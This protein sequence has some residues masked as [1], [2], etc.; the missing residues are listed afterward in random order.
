MRKTTILAVLAATLASGPSTRAFAQTSDG[1]EGSISAAVDRGTEPGQHAAAQSLEASTT[2]EQ[3]ATG[4]GRW[5]VTASGSFQYTVPI[6]L[7]AGRHGLAPG[8]SLV[9]DSQAGNGL[10]G[11]GWTLSGLPAIVRIPFDRGIR[12]DGADHYAFAA[13]GP[14]N[15][16]PA[17]AR[18]VRPGDGDVYHT[19]EESWVRYEQFGTCGSGPCGFRARLGNGT[20]LVFGENEGAQRW[21]RDAGVTR[22]RGV[23]VWALARAY[24]RFGNGYRVSYGA[25]RDRGDVLY[26]ARIRWGGACNESGSGVDPVGTSNLQLPRLAGPASMCPAEPLAPLTK[27]CREVAFDYGARSDATPFPERYESRLKVVTVWSGGQV[28]HKHELSYADE[29]TGKPTRRSHLTWLQHV[30]GENDRSQPALRFSPVTDHF[31][32]DQ[33][34][35]PLNAPSGLVTDASGI[36]L[37]RAVVESH[38]ADVNGDGYDDV[39][40]VAQD[41]IYRTV[42]TIMGRK[43]GVGPVVTLPL[44]RPSG[45]TYFH[46][47]VGDIN[48]DGRSDLILYRLLAGGSA[49]ILCMLGSASGLGDLVEHPV[50]AAGL[51]SFVYGLHSDINHPEDFRLLAVDVNGDQVDDLVIVNLATYSGALVLGT[52]GDTLPK[53]FQQL[54]DP[55]IG[56]P[57]GSTRRLEPVVVDLDGDGLLDVVLSYSGASS[58]LVVL[59]GTPTG[60]P[61]LRAV[62]F[63]SQLDYSPV[64]SNGGDVN[65]DGIG[66]LTWAY[67]GVAGTAYHRAHTRK[68]VGLLGRRGF[69]ST[70]SG[71]PGWPIQPILE[72]A[73]PTSSMPTYHLPNTAFW[74]HLV[75]DID[76]DGI[77]DQVMFYGGC[78][79]EAPGSGAD[80]CAAGRPHRVDFALGTP[81]GGLGPMQ[82]LDMGKKRSGDTA[83]AVAPEVGPDGPSYVH[84]WKA[85]LLDLD[86]DGR[87]DLVRYYSGRA[88]TRVD[89]WRGVPGGFAEGYET[90]L[91]GLR[92]KEFS[93]T[94]PAASSGVLAA[95]VQLLAPDLNGDGKPDLVVATDQYVHVRLSVPAPTGLITRI[96]NGIHGALQ[97]D[98]ESSNRAPCAVASQRVGCAALPSPVNPARPAASVSNRHPRPLAK[99]ITEED[100]FRTLE[101]TSFAFGDGRLAPGLVADRADLGFY[102]MERIAS[103]AG[104]SVRTTFFQD[105]H[106]ARR[107]EEQVSAWTP[108]TGARVELS[109]TT[110]AYQDVTLPAYGTWSARLDWQLTSER[111]QG[112]PSTEHME[113]LAYDGFG[114]VERRTRCHK[115]VAEGAPVPACSAAARCTEERTEYLHDSV[116]WVLGLPTRKRVGD[117]LTN[118]LLSHEEM[119]YL[120]TL[121]IETASILCASAEDCACYDDPDACVSN[122][123]ARRVLT[124]QQRRYDRYG[125]PTHQIDVAGRRTCERYEPVFNTH[126]AGTTRFGDGFVL[127]TSLHHDVAGRVVEARDE[128]NQATTTSY[129]A[130][131]RPASVTRPDGGWDAWTYAYGPLGK[132]YLRHERALDAQRSAV[133][134]RYF[135]GAGQVYYTTALGEDGHWVVAEHNAFADGGY[136]RK[137]ESAPHFPDEAT[138][139]WTE[140]RTDPRGR[141]LSVTRFR[142]DPR[143]GGVSLGELASFQYAPRRTVGTSRRAAVDDRGV[144][145]G[146]V[147]ALTTT[148]LHDAAGRVH[149]IQDAAGGITTFCFDNAGRGTEIRGPKMATETYTKQWLRR[150]YDGWGRT[151]R[152]ESSA[153]G[154]TAITYDDDG[155][156]AS[157]V[158]ALGRT[159]SSSYDVLGRIARHTTPEG[160]TTYT[161]ETALVNGRGRLGRVEG[162]W[163]ARWIDEY[164]ALGRVMSAQS[165]PD[166]FD[167]PQGERFAVD[168]AGRLVEHRLPD[169]SA[170]SYEYGVGGALRRVLHDGVEQARFEDFDSHLRPRHVQAPAA[171]S[172]LRY[173]DL[174]QLRELGHVKGAGPAGET[175]DQAVAARPGLFRR[176]YAFDTHGDVLLVRD[177]LGSLGAASL[178]SWTYGYDNL[179]RL[180][181]AAQGSAA[182]APFGYDIRGN[183]T[184]RGEHMALEHVD[185]EIRTFAL[186]QL[187]RVDP[188]T[189]VR[190]CSTVRLPGE[191]ARYDAV[192]NVISKGNRTYDYDSANRLIR[193][194]DEA[195]KVVASFV[196]D[197]T[198]ARIAKTEFPG[199][200]HSVTTHYLGDAYELRR[201]N[202]GPARAA[203]VRVIAPGWGTVATVTG[204]QLPGAPTGS[205]AS[206]GY[207]T[208]TGGTGDGL[209]PGTWYPL[210]D[211]LG[212]AALV[213]DRDGTPVASYTYDPFGDVLEDRSSGFDLL[214]QKFTGKE[215][216]ATTGLVYYG[217][218]YY[219]PGLARFMTA[220]TVIPGGGGNPQ[221]LNRYAYVLGNPVKMVDPTGHIPLIIAGIIIYAPEITA[222]TAFVIGMLSEDPSYDPLPGP[223]DD[224]G[225]ATRVLGRAAAEESAIVVRRTVAHGEAVLGNA[226]EAEVKPYARELATWSAARAQKYAGDAAKIYEQILTK[227]EKY[228]RA[229]IEDARLT[230][231]TR[232]YLKESETLSATSGARG[233][234]PDHIE[235]LKAGWNEMVASVR[236]QTKEAALKT[237]AEI[238]TRVNSLENL[239]GETVSRNKG[240]KD[241]PFAGANAPLHSD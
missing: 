66:D 32:P 100:G 238:K 23:V 183:I 202:V 149:E 226:L 12:F 26:P 9:Y 206:A 155:S 89:V 106:H 75:G 61:T 126:V 180:T 70:A 103:H 99:K 216:D 182:A 84:K 168:L 39:I 40:R 167:Q 145:H 241:A 148:Q 185:R 110:H 207:A 192:G 13:T 144:L 128:N 213:T 125:N 44:P 132:Q 112:L 127:E 137:L 198:G 212:S 117:V 187:C 228:K 114:A 176:Q 71:T 141:P 140:T 174:G 2:S 157:T 138:P 14:G 48:G 235:A 67:S 5:E 11:V 1:L 163:G 28:L 159:I 69:E 240:R 119:A 73:M 172:W 94:D 154:A 19:L 184:R 151:V 195:G 30:G 190:K 38:V 225:K 76:G 218:R 63:V 50:A 81:T 129:D 124:S 199:G 214:P 72:T 33:A 107:P 108:G 130:Y 181:S 8:L 220:D 171:G 123:R 169:L 196:Y 55:G 27:L 120:D 4:G 51:D 234:S 78:P 18:L 135:D 88:G 153:T 152:E 201:S 36:R 6:E 92:S 236:N 102:S 104:T 121:P 191:V 162:P 200:G 158:D 147:L 205:I 215:H 47:A 15:A 134:L 25:R 91:V 34:V 143:S 139:L 233:P 98:Y 85:R 31:L 22:H 194:T 197:D 35:A 166:G 131:G 165:L 60:S 189:R 136:E 80:A 93:P 156:V 82:S 87:Q 3:V 29:T 175:L 109:R 239:V 142:G 57:L 223:I 173:D 231:K 10:L 208:L 227:G 37:S 49:T 217:A 90:L 86:G 62:P 83:S 230:T 161:Y 179:D 42:S 115:D 64:Q 160:A 95:S 221:G 52:R 54:T 146:A 74:Q 116:G 164:D 97:V 101:E 122:H 211:H 77:A 45:A 177:Q 24:D 96:D 17:G 65:G 43:D 150:G 210:R 56:R 219:D 237:I 16:P 105:G 229:L 133:D 178:H 58:H 53:E 209:P 222:G 170:V 20:T 21:E 204:A 46:S 203:T 68:L 7:P 111:E 59:N 113:V 41:G 193:A 232:T 118:Q 224:L 186:S 188:I 79:D